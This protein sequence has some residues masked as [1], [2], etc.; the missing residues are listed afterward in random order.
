M[1]KIGNGILAIIFEKYVFR[2]A[3]D[4]ASN[5]CMKQ[6]AAFSGCHHVILSAIILHLKWYNN[7]NFHTLRHSLLHFDDFISCLQYSKH[8]DTLESIVHVPRLYSR[9]CSPLEKQI[10]LRRWY[11]KNKCNRHSTLTITT[12]DCCYRCLFYIKFKKQKHQFTL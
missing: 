11:C 1:E 8:S 6:T 5:V 9:E 4:S 7:Q 12:Y 10:L 2:K 3:Y